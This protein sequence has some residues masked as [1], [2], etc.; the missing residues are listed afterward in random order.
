MVRL[1]RALTLAVAATILVLA[2]TFPAQANHPQTDSGKTIVFDHKTGN[3]WWVEV[4]LSGQDAGSV[5]T[6]LARDT[7]GPWVALEKKSWGAW[8]GSFHIEAG[9]DVRFRAM[10]AGS[11]QQDSCWFTHPAGV[12]QCSAPP[13]PPP[14]TSAWT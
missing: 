8:A 4:I 5:A 10:W 1:Q 11:L 3:E 6:V 2:V 9:N 13:P 14:P 12:E 7:D